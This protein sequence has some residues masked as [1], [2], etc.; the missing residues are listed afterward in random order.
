[1]KSS[2]GLSLLELLVAFTVVAIA[3]LALAMAQVTGFRTTRDALDVA[4]ARDVA[5]KHMEQM[6]ALGY[7]AFKNCP[8]ANSVMACSATNT[9][10]AGRPGYALSW[11]IQTNPPNPANPSA[12]LV[13]SPPPFLLAEV[14]VTW[15]GKRYVITS[16]FSCADSGELSSTNVECPQASMR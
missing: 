11:R 9:S 3:F 8:T 1:M 5:S 4:A 7:V 16:Y 12:T 13:M 2:Q 14:R 10:V 6:R 15:R